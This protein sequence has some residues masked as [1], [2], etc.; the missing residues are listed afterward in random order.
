MVGYIIIAVAVLVL[1]YIVVLYL[2][3][4]KKIKQKQAK[5]DEKPK[6]TENKKTPDTK[7]N[8]VEVKSQVI[9]GTMYEEAVK[10]AERAGF[11]Y[12]DDLQTDTAKKQDNSRL[13][14]DREEFVPEIKRTEYNRLKPQKLVSERLEGPDAT[15]KKKQIKTQ[16]TDS[17]GDQINN[18]SP[19]LKALL[20]N[21]ILN[22]KY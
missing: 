10:E 17:V 4:N 7:P 8:M 18:L 22:K 6:A 21:D 9:K 19:E 3:N 12:T 15:S 20:L 1:L 11:K 2:I 14:L 5:K 13:K 16:N